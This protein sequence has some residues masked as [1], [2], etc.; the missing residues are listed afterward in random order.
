MSKQVFT[1]SANVNVPKGH[2][3][4]RSDGPCKVYEVDGSSTIPVGQTANGFLALPSQTARKLQIKG[5]PKTCFVVEIVDCGQSDPHDST[6][7][8]VPLGALQPSFEDEI[9]SYIRNE[10]SQQLEKAGLPTFEEE[11]DFDVP[12]DDEWHSPYEL[13]EM[14]EELPLSELP[15][16]EAEAPKAAPVEEKENVDA[17][18]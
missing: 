8:E 1:G 9:R 6:P 11:D 2:V 13:K 15:P 14:Q 10:L 16:K 18:Q 5:S 7:I 3:R 17:S 12:E 4:V